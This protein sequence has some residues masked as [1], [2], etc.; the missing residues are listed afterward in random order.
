MHKAKT[1]EA[2]I[3]TAPTAVRV[4]L[5]E[6]RSSIRK[7]APDAVEKISYGLPYYSYHGRLAYFALHKTHI[8][9]YIPTPVIAEHQKELKNY[10]AVGATVRFPLDKKLPLTLIQKLVKARIKKNKQKQPRS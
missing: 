2:Y 6:L 5:K 7:A 10:H 3:A 1:V 8:G 9:L 4:R